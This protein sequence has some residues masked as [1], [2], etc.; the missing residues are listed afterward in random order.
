MQVRGRGN[1]TYYI[2]SSDS[3]ADTAIFLASNIIYDLD[4]MCHF[5]ANRTF[6]GHLRVQLHRGISYIPL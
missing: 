5:L 6:E 1:Y 3:N 2:P 4:S